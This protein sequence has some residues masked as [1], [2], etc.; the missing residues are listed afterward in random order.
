MKKKNSKQKLAVLNYR[1]IIDDYGLISE[2]LAH[3]LQKTLAKNSTV[4]DLLENTTLHASDTILLG[5]EYR[6][7]DV[8][9]VKYLIFLLLDEFEAHCG[10]SFLI[11][12]SIKR[13]I[14]NGTFY[15]NYYEYQDIKR[16]L[17]F[18]FYTVREYCKSISDEAYR[19]S[20][21]LIDSIRQDPYLAL[22]NMMNISTQVNLISYDK[23][24]QEAVRFIHINYY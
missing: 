20:L 2:S 17:D 10:V 13:A 1:Q 16:K 8:N 14:S 9:M 23:L 18:H 19:M 4:L 11:T 12:K 15:K 7:I 3:L 5:I 21:L 24:I 6:L 22:F